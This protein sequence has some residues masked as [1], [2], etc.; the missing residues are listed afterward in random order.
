MFKRIIPFVAWGYFLFVTY[1]TLSPAHH[2][3]VFQLFE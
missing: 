3:P 1:A 2:P